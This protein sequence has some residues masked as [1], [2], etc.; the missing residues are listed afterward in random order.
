MLR[1]CLRLLPLGLIAAALLWV[2]GPALST[3][4]YLP[5][6]VDFEQRLPQLKRIGPPKAATEAHAADHAGHTASHH[7][8]GPVRFRS[9]VVEAPTRFDVVGVAGQMEEIE[10]RVREQDEDWSEW[11]EIG[12][13]DPLYSGGSD[14]VQIRS[15][16]ER[17]A[18]NLHYVNV[19]GDA[20]ALSGLLNGVR[21][22]INSA[23]VSMAGEVAIG[24]SPKPEIIKRREWGADRNNGGCEPRR[25]AS[26]GKVKA[27]VVH[28]TVSANDYSEADAPGIVLAICRYHRNANG[29]ND[30]GYNALVDRF[31]NTYEGRAG[32]VRRAVVGAHSEGHNAETTGVATIANHSSVGASTAEKQAV[33]Q[34]LAWKLD[35]HGIRATGSTRLLSAGGTTTKAKSGKRV[36]VKRVSSHSDLNFT[37]CAGSLLRAKLPTIRRRIQKRIDRYADVEEELPPIEEKPTETDPDTGEETG[38]TL[39]A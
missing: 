13:G 8:D 17:P 34:Y 27:A 25:H 15:R 14:E 3:E 10:L 23:V 32:R 6:A 12:N 37:E 38:G 28:H 30:I 26:Y 2:A 24:A 9:P 22:A 39:S 11:V 33:I 31:G 36:R 19:A 20:T 5:S 1:K 7:D 21:G 16:G 35:Q 29:W 18:G 4:R